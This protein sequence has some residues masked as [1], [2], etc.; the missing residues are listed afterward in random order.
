ME[1]T[2]LQENQPAPDFQLPDQ[3]GRPVKLADF[4]GRRLLL[5]FYPKDATPGCSIEVADFA[6]LAPRFAK[7]GVALAGVSGGTVKGKHKFA[8]A[9]GAEFPMLTDADF[10]ASAAF[11]VH[12]QKSMMGRKYMGIVRSTFLIG[13]DGRIEKVFDNV[14]ALGHA[15]DML[16]LCG[17]G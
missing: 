5:F 4:A 1:P 13:A 12:R 15:K 10:Q 9:K 2:L 14:S 16:K 11:G 3:N 7:A 8:C 17:G 6:R